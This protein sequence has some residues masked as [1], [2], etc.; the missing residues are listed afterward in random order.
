MSAKLAFIGSFRPSMGLFI[1][2]QVSEFRVQRS[3]AGSG[4]MA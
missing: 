4:I 2:F 1:R 3:F